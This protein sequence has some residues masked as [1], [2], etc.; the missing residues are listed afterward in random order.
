M[1]YHADNFCWTRGGANEGIIMVPNCFTEDDD[2]LYYIIK[3]VIIIII[4]QA[5]NIPISRT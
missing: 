1:I 3:I 5:K 2:I 4:I